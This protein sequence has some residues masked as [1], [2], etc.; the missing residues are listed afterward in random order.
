MILLINANNIMQN[1]EINME[2]Q[3]EPGYSIADAKKII[4]AEYGIERTHMAI[5]NFVK[6]KL[7][8]NVHYRKT[9]T[10]KIMIFL[11][12][13][14]KMKEYYQFYAKKESVSADG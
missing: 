1:D 5:F 13:I 8:E 12:G 6:E 2:Y 4:E 3:M 9:A 11:S 10:N 14:I 7:I